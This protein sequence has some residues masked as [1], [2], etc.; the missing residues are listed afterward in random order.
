MDVFSKTLIPTPQPI[1][2]S[3]TS[4]KHYT[5]TTTA[6]P[7]WREREAQKERQQREAVARAAEETQRKKIAKT[8]ENFPS[9]MKPIQK[10]TIHETGKFAALAAKWNVD[11]QLLRSA[12]NDRERK[13][14][15]DTVMFIR[16]GGRPRDYYESE[17]DEIE[18]EN[19]MSY[20]E[21]EEEETMDEKFPSHG[22]RGRSTAPDIEGWRTVVRK[23]RKQPRE[24]T[25]AELAQKYRDEFFNGE[26]EDDVDHNGD[27]TE[28]NQRRE[29][30]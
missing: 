19:M 27:L 8:E 14:I 23:T 15:R 22:K 21:D 24:L 4:S 12:K 11:E 5:P 26:D 1:K 25:E 17:E 13:I 9:T 6:R 20:E 10:M 29:F 7:T 30:Y 18:R 2:M 16:S 3:S 28:R